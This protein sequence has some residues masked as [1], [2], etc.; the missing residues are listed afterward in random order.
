[1]KE[2]LLQLLRTHPA[3]AGRPSDFL[4]SLADD[5]Q[6]EI[7]R[8][9]APDAGD[10][11]LQ[12]D[13][14]DVYVSNFGIE[15]FNLYSTHSFP[16]KKHLVFSQRKRVV[17]AAIEALLISQCIDFE[18]E[19]S[20]VTTALSTTTDGPTLRRRLIEL[21]STTPKGLPN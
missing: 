16:G 4:D 10:N 2:N 15:L 6:A 20:D 21:N 3:T 12:N 1:M 8:A 18:G 14:E 19:V 5:L 9:I 13:V 11:T 7:I 17:K